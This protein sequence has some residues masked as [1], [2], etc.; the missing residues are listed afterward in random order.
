M[1]RKRTNVHIKMPDEIEQAMVGF[2]PRFGS[3]ED[4]AILTTLGEVK[5]LLTA[6]AT[7][8]DRALELKRILQRA[9]KRKEDVA[10]LQV[11]ILWQI[12]E[13]NKKLSTE[14]T[15]LPPNP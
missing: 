12:G 7:D 3:D 15:G 1:G 11:Q 4:I 6:Q 5:H 2:K 10:K 14:S 9:G 8:K 13:R